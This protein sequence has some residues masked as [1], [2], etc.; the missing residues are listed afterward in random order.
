MEQLQ[1]ADSS[2]QNSTINRRKSELK[3]FQKNFVLAS[4]AND[5]RKPETFEDRK[6]NGRYQRRRSSSKA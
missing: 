4:T 6:R 1:C 3:K 5:E 2:G